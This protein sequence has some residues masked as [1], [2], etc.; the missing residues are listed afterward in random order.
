[1]CVLSNRR[2]RSPALTYTWGK[3]RRGPSRSANNFHLSYVVTRGHLL[4]L[5]ELTGYGR[6]KRMLLIRPWSANLTDQSR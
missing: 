3:I 2:A 1:M 6:S 5:S 4:P